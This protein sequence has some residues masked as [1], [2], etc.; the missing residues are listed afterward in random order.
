MVTLIPLTSDYASLKLYVFGIEL[1]TSKI[2][3]ESIGITKSFAK[4]VNLVDI[5]N[6]TNAISTAP[7]IPPI[8]VATQ[9]YQQLEAIIQNVNEGRSDINSWFSQCLKGLIIYDNK[10]KVIVDK[11]PINCNPY[12][13]LYNLSPYSEKVVQTVI[14]K[15]NEY[16]TLFIIENINTL[17][18]LQDIKYNFSPVGVVFICTGFYKGPLLKVLVK[19]ALA[20]TKNVYFYSVNSNTVA[21]FT[22]P[23]KNLGRVTENALILSHI[24][25]LKS[26]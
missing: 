14:P 26:T 13:I 7:V 9:E 15:L 4:A 1:N 24:N 19:D 25:K 23:D 6:P 22:S 18:D 10:I 2:N 21:K 3:Q 8:I 16:A 5:D 20:V 17:E 12:F 11:M